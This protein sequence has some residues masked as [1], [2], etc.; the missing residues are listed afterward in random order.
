MPR[1]GSAGANGSGDSEST[2]PAAS[3]SPS[4]SL[5]VPSRPGRAQTAGPD[6]KSTVEAVLNAAVRAG[7]QP[8]T[9]DVRTALVDAGI[10]AGNVEVTASRTPT[11][12]VTDALEAAVRDG[13]NCIV[14][15]IRNGSVVVTVL[16][17]LASGGC[18]MG[19]RD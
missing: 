4:P 5:A 10:P 15:Q 2:Q 7:T 6:K 16:P 13:G 12:L 18:L 11:G 1:S 19:G 14:A 8:Q 17:G 3:P 9:D